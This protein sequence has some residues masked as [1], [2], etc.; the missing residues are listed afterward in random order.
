MQPLVPATL[1][2]T[3]PISESLRGLRPATLSEPKKLTAALVRD[4]IFIA[5]IAS[6]SKIQA[7][8]PSTTQRLFPPPRSP[9]NIFGSL[10]PI[11]EENSA[12]H[13]FWLLKRG[14]PGPFSMQFNSQLGH[15]HFHVF[16]DISLG[17]WIPQ[18]IRG[19]VGADHLCFAVRK[20]AFP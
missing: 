19:M 16:P 5:A 20:P 1:I 9:I 10:Q 2:K 18:Q 13:S 11:S 15:Q 8:N 14:N 12:W 17:G 4:A 6:P 3:R 7:K